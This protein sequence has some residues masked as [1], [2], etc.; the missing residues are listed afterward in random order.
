M[1]LLLNMA[2]FVT[3]AI[4]T[5]AVIEGFVF[6]IML[7]ISGRLRTRLRDS[8]HNLVRGTNELPERDSLRRKY[9]DIA[10]HL[11]YIFLAVNSPDSPDRPV[12][13]KNARALTSR[14]IDRSTY[15]LEIGTSI[16][17]A[18]IQ[19]FPL[20]GIFGTI[21]ALGQTTLVPDGFNASV[22]SKAFVL[23]LDTT[24]LGILFAIIFTLAESIVAPS[25]E[26]TVE[27]TARY[28]TLLINLVA[29]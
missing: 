15:W 5:L 20:L 9:D 27:E 13:Q 4:V 2:A 24:I 14:H 19:L 28:R 12:I 25:V 7:L 23:A 6:S 16:L 8:L 18:G 21:L 11:D 17:S 1:Y 10:A 26:R 3:P 22:V 29:S